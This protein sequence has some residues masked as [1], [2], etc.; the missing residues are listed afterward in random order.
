MPNLVI[1]LHNYVRTKPKCKIGI[2]A[3][4]MEKFRQIRDRCYD[5][6]YIKIW[7]K[8][9]SCL[10]KLLLVLTKFNHVFLETRQFLRR[11]LAKIAESCYHNI[12]PRSLCLRVNYLMKIFLIG[13]DPCRDGGLGTRFHLQQSN[14]KNW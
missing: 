11:K 1:K 6:K 5:I 8:C 10:L 4:Q 13:L 12:D 2:M 9:W 3:H 7:K 14:W